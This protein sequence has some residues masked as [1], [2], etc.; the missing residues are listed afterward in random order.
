M[1][2]TVLSILNYVIFFV[3]VMLYVWIAEAKRDIEY[4]RRLLEIDKKFF[5]KELEKIRK[6]KC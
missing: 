1:D 5:E 6:M 3:S 2:I 4:E